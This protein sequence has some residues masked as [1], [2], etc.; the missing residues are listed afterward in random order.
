MQLCDN[1]C[2]P[3]AVE[4]IKGPPSSLFFFDVTLDSA[5]IEIKLPEDKFSRIQATLEHW[6]TKKK[7]TKRGILSLVGLLQHDTKVVTSGRTFTARMY[8][9]AAKL[10]E[11]HFFTRLN[12]KIWLGGMPLS[13]IRMA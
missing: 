11:L 12:R 10:E 4:K 5:R 7:A 9:T 1:L 2:I 3:L 8:T 13:S 6:L